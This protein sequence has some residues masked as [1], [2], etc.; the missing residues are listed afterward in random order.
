MSTAEIDIAMDHMSDRYRETMGTLVKF[1][2]DC[3]PF[4]PYMFNQSII[5]N[6]T[7]SC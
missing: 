3:E 5:A 1:K 7:P 4:K 6:M 2:A